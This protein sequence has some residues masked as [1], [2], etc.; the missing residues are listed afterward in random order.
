MTNIELRELN[1]AIARLLGWTT[2][3]FE[4]GAIYWISPSYSWSEAFEPDFTDDP[5]LYMPLLE[6]LVKH[7]G[8]KLRLHRADDIRYIQVVDTYKNV[9]FLVQGETLGIAIC[10]ATLAQKDD[11]LVTS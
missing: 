7:F 11:I 3:T 10:K 6:E 8:I 1:E 9:I 5:C 2:R 4:S